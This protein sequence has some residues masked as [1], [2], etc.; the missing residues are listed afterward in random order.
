MLIRIT[1]RLEL[2]CD[3]AREVWYTSG[4][5]PV[6]HRANTHTYSQSPPAT[7][8]TRLRTAAG[9]WSTCREPTKAQGEHERLQTAGS[10]TQDLLAL[11]D[12]TPP[13]CVLVYADAEALPSSKWPILHHFFHKFSESLVPVWALCRRAW[14]QAAC[15]SDLG[16]LGLCLKLLF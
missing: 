10:W 2:I 15:L 3:R 4:R 11:G 9:S 13:G 6:H 14:K 12:S 1:G 7:W 8:N 16:D 5:L